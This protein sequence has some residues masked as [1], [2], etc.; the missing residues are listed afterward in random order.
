MDAPAR[1]ERLLRDGEVA[2]RVSQRSPELQPGAVA[3]GADSG[4]CGGYGARSIPQGCFQ[5]CPGSF[6]GGA[7]VRAAVS[8]SGKSAECD[9]A[10]S[11]IQGV[12][13]ALSHRTATI[14]SARNDISQPQ[15]FTD[16]Q[17]LSQIAWFDEFFLEENISPALVA[18]GHSYS[19]DDQKFVIARER[20]LL[21]ACPPAHAEAAKK[22]SIELSTTPFYH[23]ILPLV[24]DTNAG[25]CRPR[26]CPCRR[27]G[28][29]TRKMRGSSWSA[30]LIFT[31]KLLDCVPRGCG[32][33]KVACQTRRWQLPITWASSGWRP[34]KAC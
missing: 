26:A 27:T 16:L 9:W 19:L 18:K 22:G 12:M 21:G 30:D 13:G 25:R 1:A 31:K 8:V 33:R 10:L 6:R 15:D 7:A 23:P 14:R 5:A 32:R 11:A 17:V 20:E 24:C 3:D 34:T 28:F 2:G 29:G 4:L